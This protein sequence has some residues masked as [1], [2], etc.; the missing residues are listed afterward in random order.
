MLIP[1]RK[2]EYGSL[3][4]PERGVVECR[5]KELKLEMRVKLMSDDFHQGE[6]FKVAIIIGAAVLI[7]GFGGLLLQVL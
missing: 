7:L 3:E 6:V 4:R 2:P 5:H 1:A